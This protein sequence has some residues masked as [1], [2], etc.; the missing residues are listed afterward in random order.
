MATAINTST[1]TNLPPKTFEMIKLIYALA[2]GKGCSSELVV[3]SK[4]LFVVGPDANLIEQADVLSSSIMSIYGTLIKL[5]P[6]RGKAWIMLH[7]GYKIASTLSMEQF[8]QL[9]GKLHQH[10]AVKGVGK[11]SVVSMKIV[12]FKITEI[13]T[14][15]SGQVAAGFQALRNISDG[16]Y[17]RICA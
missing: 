17:K 7:E 5:C 13:G 6:I 11:W 16:Y 15:C 2:R 10:I 14:Y 8:A 12:T 3:Q 9:Q 1:Y 4:T